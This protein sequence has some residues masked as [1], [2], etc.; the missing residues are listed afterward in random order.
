[1]N[2][3]SRGLAVFAISVIALLALTASSTAHKR[4]YN[5]SLSLSLNRVPGGDSASGQLSSVPQCLGGRVITVFEN[6]N[7]NAVFDFQ[8]VGKATTDGSGAWTLPIQGGIKKGDAYFARVSKRILV[9]NR[10]HKHIC[11]GAY[12]PQVVGS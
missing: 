3:T 2:R 12:S 5:A 4:L 10:R 6:V 9:K 11:K 8:A 1:M 7:P